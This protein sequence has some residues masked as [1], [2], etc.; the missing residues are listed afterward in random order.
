[1]TTVDRMFE[2][3]KCQEVMGDVVQVSHYPCRL[4]L[5]CRQQLARVAEIPEHPFFSWRSKQRILE[6]A[7]A[8][9]QGGK[10]PENLVDMYQDA[11]NARHAYVQ[12]VIR[13]IEE[14]KEK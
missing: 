2:C 6:A 3:E 8:A 14:G 5:R 12:W 10:G 9:T 4:C 7:I 11:D 1:M 13:W